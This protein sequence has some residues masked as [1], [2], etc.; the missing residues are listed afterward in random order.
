MN[1]SLN[2][3]FGGPTED[4]FFVVVFNPMCVFG[5]SNPGFRG[6]RSAGEAPSHP[7]WQEEG[8]AVPTRIEL[9][10]H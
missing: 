5:G 10:R 8:K 3:K 7:S 9:A 4:D 2:L 1:D 6:G